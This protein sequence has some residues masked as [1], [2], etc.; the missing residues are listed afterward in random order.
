MKILGGFGL[1]MLLALAGT[2]IAI[3]G[4]VKLVKNNR[5]GEQQR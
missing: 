4:I 5:K 1:S 3:L 2:G